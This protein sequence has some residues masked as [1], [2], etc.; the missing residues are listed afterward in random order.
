MNRIKIIAIYLSTLS[1]IFFI[2][3][4]ITNI[5][6]YLAF[7]ISSLLLGST[8]LLIPYES[9]E[10]AFLRGLTFLTYDFYA[11]ME[12]LLKEFDVNRRGIY[13]SVKTNGD[14]SIRIAVPLIEKSPPLAERDLGGIITS[15][16]GSYLM[17]VPPGFSLI[18]YFFSKQEAVTPIELE[19]YQ[20]ED[21]L[22]RC[23]CDIIEL[24]TSIKVLSTAEHIVIK[25]Y[26]PI[27]E[28][29][30]IEKVFP[31]TVYSIGSPYSS[32]VASIVSYAL[33][34]RIQIFSE[35][36]SRGEITIEMDVV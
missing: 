12:K 4:F 17:L 15:S 22:S 29:Y 36:F 33:N 9:R 18:K 3:Y 30:G 23:L 2:L 7:T 31:R 25:L 32:I 16:G 20:I 6:L 11:N 24:C 10:E 8:L 28:F 19:D 5:L 35:K 27:K 14:K 13:F 1:I 21:I 34:K 26:N